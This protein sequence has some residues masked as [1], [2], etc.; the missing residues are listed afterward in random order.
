MGADAV[1]QAAEDGV[2]DLVD[3]GVGGQPG[4]RA[5]GVLP[6]DGVRHGPHQLGLVLEAVVD[7]T[8]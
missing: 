2:D 6:G 3:A 8:Q 1:P 5:G 7:D 4:E